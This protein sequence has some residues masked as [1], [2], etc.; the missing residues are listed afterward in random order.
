MWYE[1]VSEIG[2]GSAQYSSGTMKSI[3]PLLSSGL[4]RWSRRSRFASRLQKYS[5]ETTHTVHHLSELNVE[6]HAPSVS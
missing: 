4:W 6:P 3:V 5:G 1:G 2:G